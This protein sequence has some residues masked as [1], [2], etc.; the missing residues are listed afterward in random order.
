MPAYRWWQMPFYGGGLML[1]DLMAGQA[2]LGRT[3]WLSRSGTLQ[4]LGG[5]R[6]AGLMGGVA[7]WDGQ[8]DDARL[9]LAFARTAQQQGAQLFNHSEVLDLQHEHD[10]LTTVLVRDRL[11][12]AQ[13]RVRARCVVNATGVWVD[14]LRRRQSAW[15]T[16][17]ERL[18]SPSQ[19]VH[20]VVDRD[21][22]A[23]HQAL[24][25][26]RT[27]DGRVL[28]AVPWLGKLVLGTT[29]T[30]RADLPREPEAF[31]HERE[32]ILNEASNVL[33]RPVREQDV[34]SQW[35][36]LRPLVARP[37]NGA[38]TN[39][40]RLSRERHLLGRDRVRLEEVIPRV[41]HQRPPRLR[42]RAHAHRLARVMRCQSRE[43][44]DYVLTTK[45]I[46]L[47]LNYLKHSGVVDITQPILDLMQ[48]MPTFV[49]LI[50]VLVLFGLG[51]ASA[52]I[53]TFIFA[54]PAP[55]RMTYLGITSIPKPMIEAG[56]ALA[57]GAAAVLA[58]AGRI[59][60][61]AQGL[62]VPD[63]RIALGQ[64]AAAWR[65]KFQGPLIAITGS[66]GKTTVTQ[67]VASILRAWQGEA[68]HST[69]GNLNN[70]IGVPQT[71]LR[72]RTVPAADKTK[73]DAATKR[74]E[75]GAKQIEEQIEADGHLDE[76]V[77]RQL[78][79]RSREL[80]LYDS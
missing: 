32:F 16:A 39:T 40:R 53:V 15:S 55:V 33:Q 60:A 12:P 64:L 56:E 5:V 41:D 14:Q 28:F 58:H 80:G 25:V 50:P 57:A 61:G 54:M 7:Y 23:G 35:V 34:L 78:T 8:F 29:D 71:L 43:R 22:L 79:A 2:R 11:G 52:L 67:M 38:A 42:L 37:E 74:V 18:V 49:Y 20:L 66:N 45:L 19:G 51:A 73:V 77:A 65:A 27:R 24:L 68:A 6:E 46:S 3:R 21:F 26:P 47:G 9:A 69:Q 76:R 48:T 72:L 30:P 36:G 13:A 70:D 1:Y 63:T 10:G 44:G 75:A 59:P 17:P 62:E 31:A 4:A